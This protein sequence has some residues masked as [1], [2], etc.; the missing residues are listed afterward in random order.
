M[1]NILLQIS[2]P[3]YSEEKSRELVLYG[4]TVDRMQPV[5]SRIHRLS[6]YEPA[7]LHDFPFE[8]LE[9]CLKYLDPL[10]LVAPSL[11]CRAWRFGATEMMYSHVI[12]FDK[13]RARL[14]RFICG[15]HLRNIVFGAGSYK[16]KRLDL[17]LIEVGRDYVPLIARLVSSTLSSL[18]I[19]FHGVLNHY[20]YL[21]MFLS[22]CLMIKHL[23]LRYFDF[24]ID[25][26]F[27]SPNIKDGFGRLWQLNFAWC[28][29]DLSMLIDH[30]PIYN[31]QSVNYISNRV[32]IEDLSMISALSMK[33]R[34]LIRVD[35]KV[36]I[37]TSTSLLKIAEFCRALE[38]LSFWNTWNSVSFGAFGF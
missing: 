3:L 13:D 25:P 17:L 23:Q 12:L 18:N 31:L 10:D 21:E 2:S 8:V 7:T 19:S 26:T 4:T 15:L 24:G 6:I 14:G 30:T 37:E 27:I 28:G 35:L 34:T 20:E 22:Q 38:M 36:N 33:Y 9:N 32:P 1:I 5:Y 29:G 16:I 11:A